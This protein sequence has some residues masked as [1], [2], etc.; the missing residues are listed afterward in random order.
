[1][2][3]A[4]VKVGPLAAVSHAARARLRRWSRAARPASFAGC[5]FTVMSGG[6]GCLVGSGV[7][8]AP[9]C[10]LNPKP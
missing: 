5:C 2:A 9:M 4:E 10:P 6:S 7:G 3:V 8:F 1:M